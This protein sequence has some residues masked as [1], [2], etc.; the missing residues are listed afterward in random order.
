MNSRP[1]AYEANELP[2]CSTPLYKGTISLVLS[3]NDFNLLVVLAIR[4]CVVS[5]SNLSPQLNYEDVE[6]IFHNYSTEHLSS[7]HLITV[8]N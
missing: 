5:K 2:D 4:P 6:L 1:L 8:N 7:L 3:S